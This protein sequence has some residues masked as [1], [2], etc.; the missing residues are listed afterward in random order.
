MAVTQGQRTAWAFTSDACSTD[1]T[2][3]IS[4]KITFVNNFMA[5]ES[6]LQGTA[7]ATQELFACE[8][9]T[10]VPRRPRFWDWVTQHIGA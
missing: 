1:G 6:S 9:C 7:L 3:L 10:C 2:D 8:Q 5:K 4:G